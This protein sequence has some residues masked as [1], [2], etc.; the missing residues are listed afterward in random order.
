MP[1][2]QF[3]P[4][5]NRDL[6]KVEA[7]EIIEIASPLLQEEINYATNA[8]QRC[9]E[10][11]KGA[12]PDEPLP[13]LV[14]Y[15]HVI[16][17]T[18]GIEVLVSQSCAVPSIPLLR[19]SF[20]ALLTM[21]YILKE[22]CRRRAFAWLVCYVHTRLNLY[23]M[24]DTSHQRGK[25]FLAALAKDGLDKYMN[26]QSPPNITK[27]IQNLQ[28]LLGNPNYKIAED[29]YQRIKNIRKRPINWYSLFNGPSSLRELS[30][31]LNRWSEYDFLYRYWSNIVHVGDLSHFLTRT[32]AGS[33][34]FKSIRNHEELAQV[35]KFAAS[36]ILDAT[37]LM[38][39]KY[40]SGEATSLRR[41]YISEIRDRYLS[42]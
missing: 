25:E 29:E 12:A 1:T 7:K 28:S 40:R 24:M 6:R 20:E 5:L 2:K 16:G 39:N 35:A 31:Y 37:R 15:Y 11:T 14:S 34:A 17:M 26:F 41:W 19:S 21:E 18:D 42:L 38:L 33:S 4:M 10:A 8:F 27:A 23:E 32:K 9:Q 30:M 3:E 22:D 36:F 13:V